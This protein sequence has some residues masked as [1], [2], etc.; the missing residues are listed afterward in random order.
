MLDNGVEMGLIF[1]LKPW[2]LNFGLSPQSFYFRGPACSWRK[3]F[4]LYPWKTLLV[5]SQL[6]VPDPQVFIF[7]EKINIY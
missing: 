1:P 7:E 3:K 4:S 5:M 6:V 2:P